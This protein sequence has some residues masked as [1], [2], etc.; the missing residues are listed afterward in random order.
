MLLYM[1]VYNKAQYLYE[2][3]IAKFVK[4]I[5]ICCIYSYITISNKFHISTNNYH[6]VPTFNNDLI[7]RQ[8]VNYCYCKTIQVLKY[9][10]I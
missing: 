6:V 3:I 7:N 4:N 1:N 2:T 5:I 10:T 9:Q 8:K